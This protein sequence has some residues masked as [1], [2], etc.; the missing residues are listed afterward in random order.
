MRL[1]EHQTPAAPMFLVDGGAGS[2][3]DLHWG[4]F[5]DALVGE[6][7]FCLQVDCFSFVPVSDIM[8]QV[9]CIQY[10]YSE[11]VFCWQDACGRLA[12]VCS[13]QTEMANAVTW[14]QQDEE[15]RAAAPS[16]ALICGFRH[17][18]SAFLVG[19]VV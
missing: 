6:N 7:V 18:S 11:Y 1:W 8:P 3:E 16:H 19:S 17:F 12:D 4:K 10:E 14:A 2:G 9:D 15:V 13:M 5:C